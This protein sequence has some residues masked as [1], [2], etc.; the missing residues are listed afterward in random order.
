MSE[1]KA[2][3][4]F[5]I[6]GKSGALMR[7]E[8]ENQRLALRVYAEA[9]GLRLVDECVDYE[10]GK[11]AERPQLAKALAACQAGGHVLVIPQ[12]GPLS[13]DPSFYLQLHLANVDF[14]VL[15]MPQ[16]TRNALLSIGQAAYRADS[17]RK[18]QSA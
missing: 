10:N 11:R 13:K 1:R 4:Y 12:L 15:D 16:F 18:A 9:N 6:S 17:R 7:A 2:I 14:A 8:L 5:R 3:G